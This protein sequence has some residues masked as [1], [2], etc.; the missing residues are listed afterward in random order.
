M[1]KLLTIIIPTC[2]MEEYLRKCLDSIFVSDKNM[3][4]L[5]IL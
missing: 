4:L 1:N 5:E 2:N 3:Q